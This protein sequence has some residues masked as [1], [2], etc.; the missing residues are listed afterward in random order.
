MSMHTD[1]SR[2]GEDR[3]L[4]IVEIT[5]LVAQGQGRRFSTDDIHL[6]SELLAETDLVLAVEATKDLLRSSTSFISVGLINARVAE[7]AAARLRAVQE[8]PEPPTGLTQR[9][10]TTWLETWQRAVMRGVPVAQANSA[11]L[12]AVGV[13]EVRPALVA[14]PVVILKPGD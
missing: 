12:R 11:A 3:D 14:P 1:H 13:T 4:L 2:E 7:I 6:W 8:A 10:Y 9:A 5:G